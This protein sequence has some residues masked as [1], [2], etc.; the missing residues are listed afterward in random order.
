VAGRQVL[1]TGATS[2]I[3]LAGAKELTRRGAK[4]AI[5][6]RSEDRCKNGGWRNLTGNNGTP[7]ENQGECVSFVER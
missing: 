3:G 2:G 6:A 1:I 7:F 4:L 5:V